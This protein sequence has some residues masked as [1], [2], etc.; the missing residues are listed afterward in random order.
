MKFK[1]IKKKVYLKKSPSN[2]RSIPAKLSFLKFSF[3]KINYA[4]LFKTYRGALKAFVATIFIIA[5]VIVGIDFQKNL[6]LK[7]N[8]DSQREIVNHGLNFWK[9]FIIK[10]QNYPDAYFQL[11]ALEY[12]L[13]DISNAKMYLEKGLFLDPNSVNGRKIEQLLVNK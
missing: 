7:Q 5:A 9:D 6:Q 11:S 12:R 13:G 8:I 10:H 3:P 2:S 4:I 1:N